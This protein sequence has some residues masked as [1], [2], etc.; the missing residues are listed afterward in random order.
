VKRLKTG[1]GRKGS[2]GTSIE[3]ENAERRRLGE[4]EEKVQFFQFCNGF[5]PTACNNSRT[6][7]TCYRA[8]RVIKRKSKAAEIVAHFAEIWTKYKLMSTGH[9]LLYN[10]YIKKVKFSHTRYR[11]LGPELIPVYR[12]SARR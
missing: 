7:Q 4:W 2:E 3:E 5:R 8:S 11:A 6:V 10:C 1:D 9:V 12:Q